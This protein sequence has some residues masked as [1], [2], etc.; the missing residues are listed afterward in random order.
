MASADIGIIGGTGVYDP[1]LLEN[2]RQ[3]KVH[4]PYGSPSDLITLG[5]FEGRNVAILPRHGRNHT[6][7]PHKVNWRANIHALKQLGVKRILATCATGSL[8]E[9]YKPGDVVIVDQFID[10]SKN[11]HGF[12]DEGKFYHVAMAEPFCS[13]LRNILI[14]AARDAGISVH[15]KGT[16]ARIEGPQFSTKAASKMHST[17]A[18]LIG[19]T[20]VPEAILSRE[21]EIC[22]AIIA[23]ITDYDVH[24]G[25]P[26][27]F[28][29][30]KNVMA[31]NIDNTKNI[32]RGSLKQISSER[33][34]IC[35]DAL[36]GAEA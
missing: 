36:K 22:F 21:A 30:M 23:T 10:F 24:I 32:I 9:E 1:Q 26:T 31:R 33:N 18:D 20:G 12:Y 34:C 3:I 16:Y 25:K 2:T 27:P 7:P 15:E 14:K 4:T 11:V 8:K 28:E 35:K 6:I 19:M 29:E 13:E 17:Y 5:V